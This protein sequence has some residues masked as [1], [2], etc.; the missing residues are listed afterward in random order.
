[1]C[2]SIETSELLRWCELSITA[3]EDD[4][5]E[6]LEVLDEDLAAAAVA[7]TASARPS[8]CDA[9]AARAADDTDGETAADEDGLEGDDIWE[10]LCTHSKHTRAHSKHIR[11]HQQT[12]KSAR[13]RMGSYFRI[14]IELVC[15]LLQLCECA[16]A[17]CMRTTEVCAVH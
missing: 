3:E 12:G 8:L 9:S 11:A 5:L 16:D 1:M 13:A 2:C 10:D 6:E 4:E 17:L 14:V 7:A 15:W